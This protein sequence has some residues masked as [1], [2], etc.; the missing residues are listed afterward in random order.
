MI[1]QHVLNFAILFFFLI[2]FFNIFFL[3][4]GIYISLFLLVGNIEIDYETG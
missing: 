3:G 1:G 2:F 4:Q